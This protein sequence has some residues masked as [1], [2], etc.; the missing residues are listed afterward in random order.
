MVAVASFCRA[1]LLWLG[2]VA[3]GGLVMGWR[4]QVG[5]PSELYLTLLAALTWMTTLL[6]WYDGRRGDT[7]QHAKWMIRSDLLTSSAICFRL[8]HPMLVAMGLGHNLTCQIAVW[9]SWLF[10]PGQFEM[11]TLVRRNCRDPY[12]L[13]Q[14]VRH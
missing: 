14:P 5:L 1:D 13:E 12:R 6:G 7:R 2:A 8:L 10:T 3:A 9:S 4:A 11:V